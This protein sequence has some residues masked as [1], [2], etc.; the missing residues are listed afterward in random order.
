LGDALEARLALG[1]I[2]MKNGN[3][4]EGRERLEE[5]E[6]EAKGKG[7]GRIAREAGEGR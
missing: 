5:L 7:F 3:A 4:A 2:E 6:K 1:E